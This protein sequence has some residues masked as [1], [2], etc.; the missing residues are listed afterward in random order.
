MNE[1]QLQAFQEFSAA[2]AYQAFAVKR[3]DSK[4]ITST[5]K[6]SHP[7]LEISPRDLDADCFALCTPEATYDLRKGVAGAR[8]HLPEDYITKIT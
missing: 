6:E 3:R 2:K 7:M 4:N 8:E 5:L 1:E